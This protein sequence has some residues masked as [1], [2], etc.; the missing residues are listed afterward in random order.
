[1]LRGD[2][3][4]EAREAAGMTQQELG[5]RLG[6]TL[7][8]VGNWERADRLPEAAERLLRREFPEWFGQP[9]VPLSSVSDAQLLAEIAR[10]FERGRHER[11]G[12]DGRDAAPNTQAGTARA[13]ETE[14]ELDPDYGMAISVPAEAPREAVAPQ[15][16]G[17]VKRGSR[18]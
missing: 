4:R 1:M 11:S 2:E 7:R 13:Q 17:K 15:R 5:N 6:R 14:A 8:S 10:R 18:T 12:G 3:L 9:A 16:Q